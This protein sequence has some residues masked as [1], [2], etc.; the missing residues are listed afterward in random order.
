VDEWAGLKFIARTTTS[1][2]WKPMNFSR[3]SSD[4]NDPFG[5]SAEHLVL[6]ELQMP[7]EQIKTEKWG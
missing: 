7:K 1:F 5:E 6:A 2:Q 4:G 3:R